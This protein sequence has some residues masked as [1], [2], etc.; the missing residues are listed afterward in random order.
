MQPLVSLDEQ[1]ASTFS[2]LQ[3]VQ[4]EQQEVHHL[5]RLRD[6]VLVFHECVQLEFR[7]AIT[8]EYVEVLL[9]GIVMV[10]MVE[11]M[12]VVAWRMGHVRL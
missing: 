6:L 10:S 5:R 4:E 11:V 7:T 3:R 1:E 2:D 8:P 9:L 12:R